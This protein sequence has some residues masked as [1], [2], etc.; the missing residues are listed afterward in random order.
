MTEIET[1]VCVLVYLGK[2]KRCIKVFTASNC[3]H[4]A[5]YIRNNVNKLYKPFFEFMVN[6][7]VCECDKTRIHTCGSTSWTD[8]CDICTNDLLKLM[9]ERIK[10]YERNENIAIKHIKDCLKEI[11]DRTLLN[12]MTISHIN[13]CRLNEEHITLYF[14]EPIDVDSKNN[15]DNE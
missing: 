13:N 4:V 7:L 2:M 15:T 11:C 12:S 10:P 6:N 14:V 5:T 1:R 8:Y 3:D 9:R